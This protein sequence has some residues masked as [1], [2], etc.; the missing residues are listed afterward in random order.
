MS[1][2]SVPDLWPEPGPGHV[3]KLSEI[4]QEY[5]EALEP[6]KM[7]YP[8]FL[9]S[10][11]WWE[12]RRAAISRDGGRCCECG[13]TKDLEVHHLTYENRGRE[14]EHMEDVVTLCSYCHA[15]M[16]GRY[17]SSKGLTP[18][19]YEVLEAGR[20]IVSETSSIISEEAKNA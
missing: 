3:E 2:F 6:A 15:R 14:K 18:V 13:G 12:V 8:T 11:Y 16:H 9:K 19:F 7:P 17:R 5:V 4:G 20:R 10:R 1:N